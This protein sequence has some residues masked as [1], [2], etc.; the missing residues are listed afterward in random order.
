MTKIKIGN[1]MK[2]INI[3]KV[4]TPVSAATKDAVQRLTAALIVISRNWESDEL[5]RFSAPFNAS[6]D[7]F[8]L[9]IM[10]WRDAILESEG[11]TI[12]QK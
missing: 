11:V 2:E 1:K 10:Y 6:V 8:L 5:Y 3:A 9:D 12:C 7:E 4:Q